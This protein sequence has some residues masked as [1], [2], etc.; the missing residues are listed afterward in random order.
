MQFDFLHLR[1]KYKWLVIYHNRICSIHKKD[2]WV[3]TINYI[4]DPVSLNDY[5]S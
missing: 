4:F 3:M 1:Q 5:M 2:D